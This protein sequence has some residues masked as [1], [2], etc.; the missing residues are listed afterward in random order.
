MITGATPTTGKFG[1]MTAIVVNPPLPPP[2]QMISTPLPSI[3]HILPKRAKIV[4]QSSPSKSP[5]KTQ[6][7]P[8]FTIP[9]TLALPLSP[10][11]LPPPSPAAG[12]SASLAFV[13]ALK[14]TKRITH[15]PAFDRNAV[16]AALVDQEHS[17]FDEV[18]SSANGGAASEQQKIDMHFHLKEA[19]SFFAKLPRSHNSWPA[20]EVAIRI[21]TNACREQK[22]KRVRTKSI[23]V[24]E[25]VIDDIGSAMPK[26][27]PKAT[28]TCEKGIVVV[29]SGQIAVDDNGAADV[30]DAYGDEECEKSNDIIIDED[31]DDNDDGDDDDDDD[32]DAV[33]DGTITSSGGGDGEPAAKK[34]APAPAKKKTRQPPKNELYT[35]DLV[36]ERHLW[37]EH[38]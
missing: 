35:G 20:A 8:R 37:S 3:E 24:V 6:S 36:D 26:A 4:F 1:M 14:R 10:R 15:D 7:P 33:D 27:K 11:P 25:I 34:H 32:D 12:G 22:L 17:L 16:V 29:D 13:P 23:D 30:H 38:D 9:V 5:R 19:E 31:N 2:I 28:T 21:M 18:L